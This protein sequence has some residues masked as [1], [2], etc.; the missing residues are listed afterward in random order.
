MLYPNKGTKKT[1]DDR[2]RSRPICQPLFST[3]DEDT[4]YIFT[5]VFQ[6]NNQS[7]I[8]AFLTHPF[9][10]KL[11]PLMAEK[12]TKN[13]GYVTINK[14]KANNYRLVTMLMEEVF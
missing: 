6:N 7:L 5:E 4:I 10:K 2:E 14:E 8:T 11:F 13:G 3:L 1:R 9:I 12:I